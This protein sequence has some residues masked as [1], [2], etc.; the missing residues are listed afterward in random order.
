[1]TLTSYELMRRAARA[2]Y[3]RIHKRR[4]VVIDI[5]SKRYRVSSTV[6]RGI[7]RRIDAPA[8]RHW[9]A[10]ARASESAIDIG[11]NIGVWSVL[12]AT[13]MRPGA[14]ILAVEPAPASFAILADC[15]RVAEG[16]ARI[17]PVQAALG[18]RAGAAWLTLDGPIAATNRLSAGPARAGAIEV[19]LRTLDSLLVE[20]E[21]DPVVIKIDVEGA[22]VSVLRGARK[23]MTSARPTVVLEL[24]WGGELGSSPEAILELSG[25]YGYALYEDSGRV[26]HDPQTLLRENFVVMRPA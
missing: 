9:L 12:A 25:E 10:L 7:P 13:E 5:N 8:L 2:L 24:H 23:T 1:M 3:T 14:R 21:L 6:A 18:D 22:E 20:H 26:V 16:P 4:G 15:A 11:A 17:I 19:P